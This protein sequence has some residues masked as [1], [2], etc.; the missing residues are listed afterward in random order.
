MCDVLYQNKCV[1][2]TDGK[3]YDYDDNQ[4][5]EGL[6]EEGFATLTP[7]AASNE[8]PDF[9]VDVENVLKKV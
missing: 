1:V 5:D 3:D 7:A 8:V 9:N 6:F 2:H 4:E